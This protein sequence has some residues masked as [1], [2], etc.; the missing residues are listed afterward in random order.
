MLAILEL[1]KRHARVLYV[2]IDVHHGD[3]VEEAFYTTDR[4][5]TVSVYCVG[6]GEAAGFARASVARTIQAPPSTTTPKHP[7][8]KTTTQP[9]QPNSPQHHQKVSFHKYG[10]YF[11]PGTGDATDV[12]EHNG[13]GYSVNVPLK[14][15]T[16]DATFLTLYRS[17]MAKVGVG[18]G[19]VLFARSCRCFLSC[20]FFFVVR[21]SSARRPPLPSKHPLSLSLPPLPPSTPPPP[22][23][24][25][26]LH[27]HQPSSSLQPPTKTRSWRC[28]APA[29]SCCS[30]AP[31]RSR[32]TGSA[33]S[34]SRSAG[35]AR[36]SRS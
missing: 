12:G 1:L 2:D 27:H 14:D 18:G 32:T 33:A 13:R 9:Q 24:P 3:G 26:L 15:G 17:V 34:T 8:K 23:T 35:T 20:V 19:C 16:D 5:M 10:D 4:V 31:T 25:P 28:T 30:A 21:H 36:R 29:R 7:P 22:P 11:F 6:G